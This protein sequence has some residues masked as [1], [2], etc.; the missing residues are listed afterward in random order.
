MPSFK[1]D[2][3]IGALGKICGSFC[4]LPTNDPLFIK[5]QTKN[6]ENNNV[7]CPTFLPLPPIR[8]VRTEN[9]DTP[10]IDRQ[11]LSLLVFFS[12]EGNFEYMDY[13]NAE[14]DPDWHLDQYLR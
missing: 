10:L 7:F 14:Y 5:R 3:I 13:G 2:S 9:K 4:V 1:K 6:L 11:S 12:C 8:C